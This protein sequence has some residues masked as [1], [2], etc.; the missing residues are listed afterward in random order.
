M[1]LVVLDVEGVENGDG[2]MERVEGG[3]RCSK[4]HVYLDGNRMRG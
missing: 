4:R 1:G 2:G 3:Y